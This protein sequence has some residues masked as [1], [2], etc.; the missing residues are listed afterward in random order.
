MSQIKK[1]STRVKKSKWKRL[2][3]AIIISVVSSIIF[4]SL[5]SQDALETWELRSFNARMASLR[6]IFKKSQGENVSLF[7][8]DEPSLATMKEM[9]ISWPWPREL[10]ASAIEFA[11]RGK[12]RAV[13]FD[14]FF[15]EDSIYGVEDDI[16]FFDGIGAGMP[17]Y[18]VLFLSREK[19]ES[20]PAGIMEKSKIPAPSP[21]P[22]FLPDAKSIQSPPL[23]G[24]IERATGFG[25]AQTRSD[26]D[27]IY[28]RAPLAFRMGENT[29]PQIGLKVVS[30][31]RPDWEI[32]WK[33]PSQAIWGD[34]KIPLDKNGN[35][36]INYIGG[37]DSYPVY[38]LA[39]VLLSA[40]QMRDGLTPDLDPSVLKDRVVIIGVAAPGL[41]DLKPTPLSHIYPGP[42]IHATMMDNLMRGDFIT[43]VTGVVS[44]ILIAAMSILPGVGLTNLHRFSLIGVYLSAISILYLAAAWILFAVNFWIPIIAPLGSL[45]TTSF[46]VILKSYLTEGRKKQAIKRAFGQY[47]SPYVV[48]EIAKDPDNVRMGGETTEVTVFFSDIANFTSISERMS[49]HDIVHE[50]NDYLSLLS[51]IIMNHGGT[52]DKYIGDAIMAFWGAP[53]KK[54]DHAAHAM[55]AAME[56]QRKLVDFPNFTTRMGIHTGPAVV[57]NIGSNVRFNYTVIGDTVNLA[58]RLEGLNKRFGTGILASETSHNQ[59]KDTVEARMIGKVRVKGRKQP[60]GIYEPLG[61]KGSVEKSTIEHSLRFEEALSKFMGGDIA[62]AQRKFGALDALKDPVVAYYVKTC[63]E[64]IAKGDINGF[65]GVIT[66]TVK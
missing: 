10:Y 57:G 59:A 40:Q 38:P 31:L 20:L 41:Y 64:V 24:I 14:L 42:E 16:A 49:P 61:P 51:E 58:S 66:F 46:T 13:V 1:I 44:F 15:S 48:K 62:E 6:H 32:A 36:I 25:N 45:F 2:I 55:L 35:M 12:A 5:D 60:I 7:Y 27:G 54:P 28:R 22:S 53:L 33:S 47:L 65:D 3:W 4:I 56:M 34:M 18:F 29:I 11:R 52:L 23:S 30:D 8:V 37:V 39:K 43:P 50:L 26:I 21:P 63:D 19:G 17:T 9:G